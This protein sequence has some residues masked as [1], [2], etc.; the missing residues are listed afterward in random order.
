MWGRLQRAG[1][2]ERVGIARADRCRTSAPSPVTFRIG[3]G[4]YTRANACNPYFVAPKSW[5]SNGV[6]TWL[7]GSNPAALPVQL[8]RGSVAYN[9][10]TSVYFT[11]SGNERSAPIGWHSTDPR[12]K[13]WDVPISVPSNGKVVASAIF[14]ASYTITGDVVPARRI[15]D[16]ENDDF[17][18][19]CIDG[20]YAQVGVIPRCSRASLDLQSVCKRAVANDGKATA[21]LREPNPL[22]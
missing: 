20:S 4:V 14:E 13:T 8:A 5:Y 9:P 11:H 17:I 22:H 6:T 12:T 18:S 1:S 21:P 16:D 3:D 19:V 2:C 15:F 10:F 7:T